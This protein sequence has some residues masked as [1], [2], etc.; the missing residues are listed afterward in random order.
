MSTDP[1]P[2]A[3]PSPLI[4]SSPETPPPPQSWKP[5][6][7]FK[8]KWASPVETKLRAAQLRHYYAQQRK[9]R[10]LSKHDREVYLSLQ[11]PQNEVMQQLKY[12][13]NIDNLLAEELQQRI[14]QKQQAT[15]NSD[16]PENTFLNSLTQQEY[17]YFVETRKS[18]KWDSSGVK[19]EFVSEKMDEQISE[20]TG[21]E[22]DDD[23]ANDLSA[24]ELRE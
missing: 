16:D 18:D 23:V 2:Q 1:S 19:S 15:A 6:R 24:E 7:R 9:L 12:S 20:F 5:K 8:L 13:D 14:L 17:V 22:P 21:P 4:P 3:V 11:S 10:K